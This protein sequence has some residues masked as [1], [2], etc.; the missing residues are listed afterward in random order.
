MIKQFKYILGVAL[1]ALPIFLAAQQTE[2]T[3]KQQRKFDHYFFEASRLM[4]IERYNDAI[5]AYREC[6]K[7]DPENATVNFQLGKLYLVANELKDGERFLKEAYRLDQN[8][9]WIGSALAQYYQ[10]TGQPNEAVNVYSQLIQAHPEEVDFQFE[11]AKIYFEK[12]KYKDCIKVLNGLEV[13]MGINP[14]LSNQKKDIYLLLDDED[15]ARKELEKLVEAYPMSIE[16]MGALAQ[17]Y[18]ANGFSDAAIRTYNR[19]LELNPKDPRA[20]L[21]LAN[22]YRNQGAYD[23]SVYH[24]KIA[25]AS[26]QLEVEMKMKVIYSFFEEGKRDSIMF[27]LGQELLGMSINAT[28][29]D[30]RLHAL[31]GDFKLFKED[32]KGARNEYRM[33]TRL[34]ASD[35]PIWTQL[36]FLDAE[37]QWHDTLVADAETFIELYPNMPLGYLMAGSGYYFLDN[38]RKSIE[39]YEAG[40]DFV[41]DNPELEEQFYVSLADSYHRLKQ[42]Q[43][44]DDYFNKALEINPNNPTVLNN[45]AYYL[46]V[47]GVRLQDAL[48]MAARCDKIAP[49]NPTFQDT[50]AWALYKNGKY[51]DALLYIEE[52][53][54]NGG[55]NS[56][57]VLEHWG[58]ILFK[59]NRIEKAVAKWKE[60]AAKGG[61]SADIQNKI[62]SQS[63]HD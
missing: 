62:N 27:G 32:T 46:S 22:I 7:I 55:A 41:I 48:E 60:A 21:D 39:M 1:L 63:L 20:H 54:K 33:A 5:M 35:V 57:E 34:G 29:Q 47:R 49:N 26:P 23:T 38:H 31:S 17:F 44:S 12:K 50:Y 11:L 40:L 51:D 14:E 45:Y 37:L 10:Q 30:H 28:P 13:L 36:L 9:K 19:M 56:G 61:A 43:R 25:M 8:N 52:C 42:H 16:Y 53:A 2:L 58:D 59:L 24:L 6:H 4:S 3:D 18:N 15:G